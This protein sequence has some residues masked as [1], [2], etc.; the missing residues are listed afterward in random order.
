[1]N[2][3]CQEKKRFSKESVH[4]PPIG[5]K[6]AALVGA[7]SWESPLRGNAGRGW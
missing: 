4:I 3:H 2:G 1:M 6:L 7:E 5:G